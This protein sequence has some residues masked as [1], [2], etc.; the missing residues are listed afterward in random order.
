MHV[1]H[2]FEIRH[3]RLGSREIDHGGNDD[4]TGKILL[5]VFS[6]PFLLKHLTEVDV[7]ERTVAL[8]GG[9]S[10]QIL[11]GTIPNLLPVS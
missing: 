9:I 1:D 5:L 6:R 2:H 8:I 3:E 10:S 11:V 7:G 4:V